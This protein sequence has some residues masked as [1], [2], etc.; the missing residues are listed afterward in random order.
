MCGIVCAYELKQ[1][2]DVLRPQLLEMS[3]KIRHRG[4]D[5]NGVYSDEKAILAHER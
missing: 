5:W 1:P 3:K 2:A 4:P